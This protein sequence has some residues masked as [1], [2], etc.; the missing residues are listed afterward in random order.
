MSILNLEESF[1][2]AELDDVRQFYILINIENAVFKDVETTNYYA[3]P[4]DPYNGAIQT[5]QKLNSRKDIKIIFSSNMDNMLL[6]KMFHFLKNNGIT[7]YY[8]NENSDVSN[9]GNK[10][11]SSTNFY[12]NYQLDKRSGF[13]PET[14]WVSLGENLDTIKFNKTD[15]ST[16]Y[17]LLSLI[18]DKIDD[19]YEYFDLKEEVF[20]NKTE[21]LFSID[22]IKRDAKYYISNS[23]YKKH[24]LQEVLNYLGADKLLTVCD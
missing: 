24:K 3:Y 13:E 6:S 1:K 5:L 23:E 14:D 20:V 12:F 10:Y 2:K 18:D 19:M 9:I 8:F 21:I 11:Y 16:M 22:K 7:N 4:I 17:E 15:K